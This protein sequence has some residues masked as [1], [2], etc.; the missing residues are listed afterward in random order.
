MKSAIFSIIILSMSHL[1]FGQSIN[2]IDT[3]S[4]KDFKNSEMF[5]QGT[6]NDMILKLGNPDNT[7]ENRYLICFQKNI[8]LED[9]IIFDTERINYKTYIYKN[10]GLHYMEIN[11]VVNLSVIVFE[12]NKKTTLIHPKVT[13]SWEL[14]LDEFLKSFPNNIL[15][16]QQAIFF[17]NTKDNNEKAYIV[18]LNTGHN[19]CDG[20]FTEVV[21]DSK[22]NLRVIYFNHIDYQKTK[23]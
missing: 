22:K 4:L 6:K 20:I 9:S 16:E 12:K 17:F 10:I 2:D 18:R 19:D 21:F 11:E 13:F 23:P 15:T 8:N 3:L 7:F 14:K 1:L 5:L